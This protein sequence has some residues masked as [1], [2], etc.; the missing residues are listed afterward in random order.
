MHK[1]SQ[2]ENKATKWKIKGALFLNDILY[3]HIRIRAYLKLR[4]MGGK[5]SMVTITFPNDHEK[6]S[7]QL[8][9]SLQQKLIN[10]SF[11]CPSIEFL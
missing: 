3:R 8:F 5:N 11:C 10:A 9:K 6:K 7:F 4:I 2:G 1:R